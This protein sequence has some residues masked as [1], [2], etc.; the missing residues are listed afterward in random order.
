MGGTEPLV[1]ETNEGQLRIRGIVD[2]LDTRDGEVRVIDY[3][4]GS[5]HLSA[6][7]L[8][9]GRRLQLPLY[10]LAAERALDLGEVV[11][12]FYWAIL[13]ARRGSLRLANFQD[14]DADDGLSG[15]AAAYQRLNS[16]LERF[17]AGG[18]QGAFPPVPPAGGCP[19]YCPAAD[20]CWRYSPGYRG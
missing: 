16:H 6:G 19:T 12:G 11:D 3:K 8:I 7:D 9:H 20:W 5:S 4:I 1:I 13:A 18:R 14:T 17:L 15:P 2:R 10:A